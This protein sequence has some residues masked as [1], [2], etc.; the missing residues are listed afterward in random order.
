MSKKHTEKIIQLQTQA[1]SKVKKGDSPKSLKCHLQK[2]EL[3][4]NQR[5]ETDTHLDFIVIIDQ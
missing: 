5:L 3:S 4:P 2:G 1:I